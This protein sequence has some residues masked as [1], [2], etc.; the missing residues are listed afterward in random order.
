MHVQR[1]SPTDTAFLLMERRHMPLHV[2][3]L[4]LLQ[5]PKDA[6][7]DFAAQLAGR[8]LQSAQAA[9]PFNLRP[10][11]RFGLS[12]WETD[13]TFDINQHLVHLA[14][15][16]PGRIRELLAMC[17]RVHAQH[18]DRAYPLWRMYLI[19]GLEDGR[20]AMFFKIHHS[21]VDGVAAMRLMMK[22]M[23]PDAEESAQMPPTWEM[24][25][26]HREPALPLSGAATSPMGVLAGLSRGGLASVPKV[27]SNLKQTWQDRRQGNPDVV[28]STQ[29]PRSILNQPVTA[30]RR[31]AAQSYATSRFKAIAAHVGGTTNDVVLAVCAAALRSYLIEQEALPE[32]PLVAVVPVS[33]RRDEGDSGNEIAFAMVNLATHL[34][35]PLARLQA[36]KGCMDYN[37]ARFKTM[38]PAELQA[39]AVAQ[40]VPGALNMLTGFK[41]DRVPANLVIS[42]VPGPR[43]AM[44]WQGCRLDGIYPASLV[45]DGFALN[46]TVISRHDNVDFGL[47]GCRRTVPSLQR[48]LDYF[49]GGIA[50]LEQAVQQ[51][52]PKPK[53]R[54]REASVV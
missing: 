37:K 2:G 27:F 50:E 21:V 6:P 23:S 20:I 8:L 54:V 35:D 42:H 1:L 12:F 48:L 14:L 39:Y 40:L 32:Q 16:K 52:A 41:P 28:T 38:S 46:I 4:V 5:P 51:Q 47:I 33:I 36:I 25:P 53:R 44:Y 26:R 43:Q 29:A 22:S 30:S 49:E 34:A 3:G 18:L 17:S 13:S 7:P 15:P 31:F 24:A 11:S 9:R 45:I 10:Q 19:E